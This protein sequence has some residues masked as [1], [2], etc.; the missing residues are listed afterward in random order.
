MFQLFISYFSLGYYE[1]PRESSLYSELD[2]MFDRNRVLYEISGKFGPEVNAVESRHV[3]SDP[4]N[5][6]MLPQPLK[7]DIN[8]F[9]PNS[10]NYSNDY[11][12]ST[13]ALD[14]EL[15]KS[16]P[17]EEEYEEELL[18]DQGNPLQDG[19]FYY[20]EYGTVQQYFRKR[21][22]APNS[23]RSISDQQISRSEINDN[24]H[25]I[26]LE[27][28]QVDNQSQL[29]ENEGVLNGD[30][31]QGNEE[32]ADDQVY[33]QSVVVIIMFIF[34]FIHRSNFKLLCRL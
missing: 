21:K 16:E 31:P 28:D 4:Q 18:D 27:Q 24:D 26:V 29:D 12:A 11:E 7:S 25:N 23:E 34:Y 15:S 33:A 30:M 19:Q 32:V 1:T 6:P 3:V 14:P 20:D 22:A 5:K 10:G 9:Y 2:Y 8:P 17:V 13:E